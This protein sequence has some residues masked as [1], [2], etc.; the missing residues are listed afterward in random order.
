MITTVPLCDI[1][2]LVLY[3][4]KIW[5]GKNWQIVSYSLKLSSPIFIDTPKL[6]LAY[7]MTLAYLPI[8]SS[9]IAFTCMVRQKV[10]LP[11][12]SRVW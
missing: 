1:Y 6:Y 8:F 10:P 7:A 4:E 9:P 11:N 3:M 2:F 12:F 5:W